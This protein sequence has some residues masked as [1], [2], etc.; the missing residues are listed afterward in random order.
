MLV[1]RREVMQ[2]RTDQDVV[3]ARQAVRGLSIEL[4]FGLVDITKIVTASSELARN[5]IQHGGGGTLT[6][7][8]VE[9]GLRRGVRLVFEDQGRGIPDIARALQDGY[10]T[11]TGM[12]LGLGGSRRLMHDFDIQSESGKGT[13]VTVVRWK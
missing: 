13:R 4:G 8:A 7:E 2:L 6:M 12:G 1:R 9:D 3:R 10:T 5:A 11:G